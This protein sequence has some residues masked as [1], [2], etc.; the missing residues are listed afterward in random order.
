[1]ISRLGRRIPSIAGTA[2]QVAG[3]IVAIG[4]VAAPAAAAN[5]MG[6]PL[7]ALGQTGQNY[8]SAAPDIVLAGLLGTGLIIVGSVI[9]KA[10]RLV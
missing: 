3:G 7:G 10:N 6:D 9:K 2:V 8:R 5:W 1:M 4:A